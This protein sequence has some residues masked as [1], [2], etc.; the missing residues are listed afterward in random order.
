MFRRTLEQNISHTG[1]HTVAADFVISITI[2]IIIDRVL[3]FAQQH[4]H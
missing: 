1:A 2:V 3:Q 4:K